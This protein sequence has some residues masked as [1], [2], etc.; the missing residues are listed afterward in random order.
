M[1]KDFTPRHVVARELKAWIHD[2]AELALLDVREHGQFGE[3]HL[4]FAVPM[5]YSELELHIARLVPRAGT[6][7]VVYGD[8]ANEP[9]VLDA[10]Q[11]PARPGYS[12]EHVTLGGIQAGR[13]A[14]Y[15]TFPGANRPR[16]TPRPRTQQ[17][18]GN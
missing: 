18:T 11:A 1:M 5:P 4:F 14:G 13:D 10:A 3:N 2:P 15:A 9:P 17:T 8:T 12:R 16:N 7:T 6:R